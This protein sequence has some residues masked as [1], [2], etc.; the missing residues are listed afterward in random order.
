MALRG[1]GLAALLA[2]SSLFAADLPRPAKEIR[3]ID[4]TGQSVALSALKGKV[5]IVEFL[6]THCPTCQESARLLS[7]L[8][9]EYGKRGLQ[10]IG[11]GINSDAGAK[12]NEFVG[13]TGANFPLG[14]YP[15][16]SFM[17]W[18]QLPTISNPV[19]PQLA[20]IDRK[21]MVRE[22]HGAIETWMAPAFEEKNIRS[23]VEKLLSEGGATPAAK[24]PATKK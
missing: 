5:V 21:G 10:V 11:L 23:L 8:Q 20:F 16:A 6:L 13:K 7:Q 3:F 15:N 17:E 19:M 14:V 9:T 1:F 18:L 24:K 22:Q 12:L 4:H 2:T